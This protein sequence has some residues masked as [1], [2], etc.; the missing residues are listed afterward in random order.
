MKGSF[1]L[2]VV[3]V[4]LCLCSCRG[5]RQDD[6][7]FKVVSSDKTIEEKFNETDSYGS[8]LEDGQ[9]I[10]DR[11]IGIMGFE[12]AD[13][14]NTFSTCP[15]LP[16]GVDSFGVENLRIG[17]SYVHIIHEK[18][19]CTGIEHVSGDSDLFCT[20]NF[21]GKHERISIDGTLFNALHGEADG[22]E[23]SFIKI[24]LPVHSSVK[25]C[26]QDE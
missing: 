10:D 12:T 2:A 13:K 9:R 22:K 25:I 15:H 1:W 3:Q 11:I 23:I 8:T 21:P 24:T 14:A 18:D 16:E 20:V 17:N 19:T 7:T 6:C 26:V 4:L 5:Q